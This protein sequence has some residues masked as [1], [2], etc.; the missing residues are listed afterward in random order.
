MNNNDRGKWTDDL[1]NISI[2]EQLTAGRAI[3]GNVFP[4]AATVA[5]EPG[6]QILFP[7]PLVGMPV[8]EIVNGARYGIKGAVRHLLT[9]RLCHSGRRFFIR[10]TVKHEH[11]RR[12]ALRTRIFLPDGRYDIA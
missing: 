6:G 7:L 1:R 10:G 5:P 4:K 3:V 8:L 9:E 11:F 2:H 12:G